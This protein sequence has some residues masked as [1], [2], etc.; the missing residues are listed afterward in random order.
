MKK[1]KKKKNWFATNKSELEHLKIKEKVKNFLAIKVHKKQYIEILK[2]EWVTMEQTKVDREIN[3]KIIF[4]IS[5]LINQNNKM[6]QLK[7]Y[8]K[9]I[10]KYCIF[11]L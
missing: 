7:I 4:S 11:D 2:V 8:Y 6:N 9:M 3:Q 10:K 1:N 5:K